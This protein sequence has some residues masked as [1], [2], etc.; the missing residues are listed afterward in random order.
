MRRKSIEKSIKL[1]I[2]WGRSYE[3]PVYTSLQCG[4]HQFCWSRLLWIACCN[5]LT[6]RG[7]DTNSVA[8]EGQCVKKGEW[9]QRWCLQISLRKLSETGTLTLTARKLPKT[10]SIQ[11]FFIWH[12]GYH[13]AVPFLYIKATQYP[14][15]KASHQCLFGYHHPE[16]LCGGYS[17]G[18]AS[19]STRKKTLLVVQ[20][21]AWPWILSKLIQVVVYF[22]YVTNYISRTYAMA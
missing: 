18:G 5:G 16:C 9:N 11:E 4:I 15:P 1:W 14:A 13:D 2:L 21:R 7:F 6:M 22:K 8:A 3:A 10:Y 20:F 19:S 17:V 12:S